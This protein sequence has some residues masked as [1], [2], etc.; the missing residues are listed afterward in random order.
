MTYPESFKVVGTKA[1]KVI[2]IRLVG[3]AIKDPSLEK[4]LSF[5]RIN[6]IR[7]TKFFI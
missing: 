1:R 3:F 5:D 6:S 2:A 7:D 4:S